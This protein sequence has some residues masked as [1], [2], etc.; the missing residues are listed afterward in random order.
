MTGIDSMPYGYKPS[1]SYFGTNVIPPPSFYESYA[2]Q[3]RAYNYPLK[4]KITGENSTWFVGGLAAA[5]LF[6]K[7]IKGGIIGKVGYY[8][9]LGAAGLAVT[10]FIGILP[11]NTVKSLIPSF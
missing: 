2:Y 10:D 3:T 7:L 4:F 5:F 8:A 1:A 9:G 6:S 11:I